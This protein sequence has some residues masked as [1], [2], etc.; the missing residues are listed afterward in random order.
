[1]I[2]NL[3]MIAMLVT[4]VIVY[5]MNNPLGHDRRYRWRCFFNWFPLGLT[6]AFLYMGRYN[7]TVSKMALGDLMS[8][9]DF[10]AI[11]AAG[12]ITYAF[13]FLVNGPLTDKLGGRKVMLIS[14]LGTALMNFLMGLE[15][16]M[17]LT[18]GWKIQLGWTFS[19]LYSLN[20][21][22]QSFG[23]TSI[24]K[25]NANWFHVKE[26]G[27]FGGIFGMLIAMGI[28]LAFDWGDIITKA[29]LAV[30]DP[31]S[32]PISI[33]LRSL[34]LTEG[35]TVNG[36]WWIFYIPTIVLLI[37]FIIDYFIVRDTPA[38]A[39][40]PNIETADASSGEDDKPIPTMELLKRILTNRV[41]IIICLIQVCSGVLRQGL[42]HW[43]PIYM[44]EVNKA[45]AVP[46]TFFK[47]NWGFLL[48]IAG[49]T[50]SMLAGVISD[51]L[52]GS[53]RGPVA[54]LLYFITLLASI[55]MVFTMGSYYVLGAMAVLGSVAIIGVHGMLAGTATMDFGGKK[56]A[57]TATGIVDGFVYLGTGLQSLALGYITS[58]NW[59]FW[60][61]FLIPF[62]IIGLGF[63]IMIWKAYPQ[64]RKG[65]GH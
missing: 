45:M 58:W 62:G 46:I 15:I 4:V 19:I 64:A 54:A 11:F 43:F 49:V 33:A 35:A 36:S 60:P 26:R 12:S 65:G 18:Q 21:Y 5:F 40:L 10:G 8:K 52:F 59:N 13:A 55:I 7:L 39:G 31:N 44:D 57:G 6:Y 9:E 1:M 53:R 16:Y 29:T 37:F 48:M 23:A 25:V 38:Q 50:G 22:F 2:T 56:A 47:D 3:L 14:A 17:V 27:V 34:L 41:I 42:M 51:K 24:V 63:S 28:F 61:V 20:M 32:N 30:A